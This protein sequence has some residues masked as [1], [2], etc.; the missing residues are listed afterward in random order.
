M[1]LLTFLGVGQYTTVTYVWGDREY[2]T[3]LFPTALA[4]WL[5]PSAVVVLLTPEAREHANWFR[6]QEA[7]AGR[8]G[9]APVDIPLGRSEAE[10][11]QIFGTLTDCLNEG[12][13]VAFDV[14]HA[15]RSIPLLSLLVAAYLRVAK[16]VCLQHLFYGAFE[17]RQPAS[18][19]PQPT[20]RA[21]V[22]D[23][24]PFLKLLDWVTATDKFVGSGDGREL[25]ELLRAA[26]RLPWT[27]GA[28]LDAA[29]LPRS[30]QG[31]GSSLDTLSQA[32]LL[33][34]PHEIA[35]NAAK[36]AQRL[37]EAGAEAVRWAR[38]F[39]VLLERTRAAYEPFTAHTLAS[40]RD[41][42]QWYFDHGY[43]F[44]GVTLARE[45]V[46]SWTCVR[47]GQDRIADRE[48]V[49]EALHQAARL[50]RGEGGTVASP[51]LALAEADLL[52]QTWDRVNDLRNDIAHCGHRSQP[53]PTS[54]IVEAARGL[55]EQLKQLPLP[56]ESSP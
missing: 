42:I 29:P 26:H 6:L 43:L 14:T 17:A 10:L 49:E 12:D 8:V 18:M 32:L 21:P 45:W 31:L 47:L 1:K 56:E 51:L 24:S 37:D 46:V 25:A 7:L 11:W 16:S 39:T 36:L 19:P 2:T 55:A 48:V 5:E 13:T 28:P 41:L 53:R 23:L 20:D 33:A 38:P 50:R 15:F 9:L 52:L 4:A 30:L 54:R 27:A 3:S 40:Q 22:F 34:R 44:Q 35:E